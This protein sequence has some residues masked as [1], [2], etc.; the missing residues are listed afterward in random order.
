MTGDSRIRMDMEVEMGSQRKMS[1]LG[2]TRHRMPSIWSTTFPSE[3]P[4]PVPADEGVLPQPEV[5]VL[6]QHRISIKPDLQLRS[7]PLYRSRLPTP[8]STPTTTLHLPLLVQVLEVSLS[9][10]LLAHLRVIILCTKLPTIT[11]PPRD[12]STETN[13]EI[14]MRM[15]ISIPREKDSTHMAQLVGSSSCPQAP[16]GSLARQR[17]SR[18]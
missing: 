15:G 14:T 18:P 1:F 8:T 11:L 9:Q 2:L 13:I 16:D 3:L 7:S 5:L 17:V 12:L 10:F 4:T 6:V